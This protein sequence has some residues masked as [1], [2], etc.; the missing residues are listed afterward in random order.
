MPNA[1]GAKL[2]SSS[3]TRYWLNYD[4]GSISIGMG[5]PGEHLCYCWADPD[6]IENI[7]FAGA[8]LAPHPHA[9][10][11]SVCSAVLCLV[12]L[13]ALHDQHA[14]VFSDYLLTPPLHRAGLSAWDKHVGYRNLRMHPVL[15]PPPSS[16]PPK[17]QRAAAGEGSDAQQQQHAAWLDG[18]SQQQQQGQQ[19]QQHDQQST[20]PASLLDCCQATLR[21]A[22][23]PGSVCELLQV[24]D[25]LAPVLDDLRRWATAG[26]VLLRGLTAVPDIGPHSWPR[27]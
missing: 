22:L 3:F 10:L 1:P 14:A 20:A 4:R 6:P 5:E 15:Q 2:S 16:P 24:A 26:A 19:P 8:S 12:W 7:R 25:C 13:P 18:T 17:Q 11:R 27:C 21:A 9:A 23:S